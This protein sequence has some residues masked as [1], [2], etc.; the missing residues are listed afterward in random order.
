[1]PFN[2]AYSHKEGTFLYEQDRLLACGIPKVRLR[3]EKPLSLGDTVKWA[4][5]IPRAG[6]AAQGFTRIKDF[7]RHVKRLRERRAKLSKPQPDPLRREILDL[8]ASCSTELT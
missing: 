5:G 6:R 7:A 3:R 8:S 1:M 4:R 2:G